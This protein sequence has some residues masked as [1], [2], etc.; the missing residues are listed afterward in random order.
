MKLIIEAVKLWLEMICEDWVAL[1]LVLVVLCLL[2][3][4]VLVW[5]SVW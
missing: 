2:I 3:L 1:S 4:F 5:V